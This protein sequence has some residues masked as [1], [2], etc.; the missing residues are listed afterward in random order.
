MARHLLT[1]SSL[2]EAEAVREN[3]APKL[4]SKHGA[5]SGASGGA[6]AT[7]GGP[8]GGVDVAD[9]KQAAPDASG[10]EVD[11]PPRKE[12]S[13]RDV[14]AMSGRARH[15]IQLA[16][17]ALASGPADR[18]PKP[19]SSSSSRGPSDSMAFNT[20]A[21]ATAPAA[22]PV[23]PQWHLQCSQAVWREIDAVWMDPRGREDLVPALAARMLHIT[24]MLIA[25]Y[26]HWASGRCPFFLSPLKAVLLGEL[27][28]DALCLECPMRYALPLAHMLEESWRYLSFLFCSSKLI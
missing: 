28:R 17:P 19:S 6:R 21:Q 22:P 7:R 10:D 27:S 15:L 2:A 9:S 24:T 13:T 16:Y 14:S 11:L 20:E 5:A 8:P 23:R 25:K 12:D 3:D 4:A 18:G 1:P 26:C